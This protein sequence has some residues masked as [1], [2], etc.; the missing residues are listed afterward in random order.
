MWVSQRGSIIAFSLIV[1]SFMLTAGLAVITVAALERKGGLVSQKSTVAFQAADS[2]AERVLE[3]IYGHNSPSTSNIPLNGAMPDN[4]LTQL[5]SNL[6]KV[7]SASCDGATDKVLAT[8]DATPVYNLE[9]S[10]FDTAGVLIDCADA[11]WR[12]AVVR[13]RVEGFYASTARVVETGVKP[14]PKCGSTVDDVDGNTYDVLDIAGMCWTKQSMQ[15]GTRINTSTA[16]SN[17]GTIEYYCHSDNPARCTSNHPNEPD[18]GL[19][20][21]GEAMQYDS[22]EGAQGICPDDWHV[23]T[24][25]E[26]AALIQYLDP[27]IVNPYAAVQP[28]GTTAGTQLK[29]G[30][31][32]GFEGNYAG[33]VDGGVSLSRDVGGEFW[34]S[35]SNDATTAWERNMLSGGFDYTV[36]RGAWSKT[37]HAIS[38]R[39]VMD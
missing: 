24:D 9:I 27:T 12:D 28:P 4:T 11:R 13:I 15:V 23:S 22:T 16:Q 38:V 18:G 37:N 32:S 3:R 31:S 1:L 33:A 7:G 29:P 35:T 5:A 34:T 19:Y 39:C 8:N 10:F 26:W 25:G 20:D 2:G 14:R 21:W 6:I 30:G 17:N 36:G